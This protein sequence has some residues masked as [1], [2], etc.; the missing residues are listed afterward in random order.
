[1]GDMRSFRPA[2]LGPPP[3]RP[4]P[5]PGE[6]PIARLVVGFELLAQEI[7]ALPPSAARERLT[8]RLRE[9]LLDLTDWLEEQHPLEE[10]L[11]DLVRELG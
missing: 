2:R 1:M 10:Q 8:Q 7:E 11:A 6:P 3:R 5:Q 9:A 4:A